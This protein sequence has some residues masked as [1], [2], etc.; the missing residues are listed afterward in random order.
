MP[1]GGAGG[2]AG[3]SLLRTANKINVRG[4]KV[5]VVVGSKRFKLDAGQ[6]KTLTVTLPKRVR[7]I[8]G[9]RARCR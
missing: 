8:A 1:G 2:C 4:V 7:K 9:P 3:T 5:A 6:R